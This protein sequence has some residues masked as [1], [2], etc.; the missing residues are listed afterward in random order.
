MAGT[1][2]IADFQRWL[3]GQIP[4]LNHMGLGPFD[5]DGQCLAIPAALG[6]NVNDK[7]TG[8]G[9][10][11]ATLA[12]ICGWSLVT[13]L[14]RK[15]GLD[16]DLVIAD[17]HLEYLSPVDA[18]FVARC[19]LPDQPRVD[20]FLERLRTRRKS[21]LE[22]NVELRQGERVAMRMRGRYVAL[23]RD[24]ADTTPSEPGASRHS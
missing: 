21:R 4:L 18:D 20:S 3:L 5:Y 24:V 7:G 13:L 22:L 2:D 16:C 14:L 9:G 1:A 23:L 10:S 6:P 11:Q 12:T 19:R 17:S 8:F 15:Q